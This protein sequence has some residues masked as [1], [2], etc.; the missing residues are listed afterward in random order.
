MSS[1]PPPATVA[2][3]LVHAQA[4]GL[5]RLDAQMLVLHALGRP[6]ADRAWL[7]AHDS[8][9]I[10][11]DIAHALHA[12]VQRRLHGEPVAY[13]TGHKEFFGMDLLVDARVLVP[14]PDTEALVDWALDVLN[15][16][17]HA[18]VLDLGTGSGAIAL[19]I[20]S[21]RPDVDV[22]ARDFSADALQV[23]RANAARLGLGIHFSQGSWFTDLPDRY[24][25]V[26]SNPPYIAEQD[27]HLPALRHEPI[28]ALT[29]G[30]DGLDDIR[31]IIAGAGLHLQSGGWLLLEHGHD[32][33]DAVCA[34]LTA[35]GL[36]HA[37]SRTDLTGTLR[38]SGA[39]F[40]AGHTQT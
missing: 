36:K 27:S 28:Q 7:L 12:L 19:A 13:I 30:A 3:A 17:E 32:Q 33:S 18:S 16:A 9:A 4:Q 21:S 5:A 8:D 24:S 6:L 29:S 26:V 38:C 11:P 10:V 25:V 39:Q 31:Q 1:S 14:R 22:H 34:L 15:G 40:L 35:A 23:A 37:Q 20:K 2:A